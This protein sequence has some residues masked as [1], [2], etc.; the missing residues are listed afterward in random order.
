MLR[1]GHAPQ[2]GQV[3]S[4]E[5]RQPAP[6]QP[7][8]GSRHGCLWIILFLCVVGVAAYIFR[9]R[10][11]PVVTQVF[12]TS[13]APTATLPPRQ[14]P[15]AV[16]TARRGDLP[17]YLDAPGTVSALETVAVKSRV[18]GQ[19]MKVFFTEGRMVKAGDL[20]FQIDPR[21]FE[22]Q[23]MQAQGQ[24][25]RDQ[26]LL[27][28]AQL[29][30]VRYQQAG[31]A[32][33][34]QQ[35]DTARAA[36]LQ[37]QGAVKVD[38]GVIENVNLQLSYCRITSP[39]DG[40]IGLELVDQGNIVHANDTTGLALISRL[41]PINVLFSLAQDYLPRIMQAMGTGGKLAV[42]VLS[43]DKS[44]AL[45][46]GTLEAV[47][48]QID[49]QTLT[50]RFK[51]VCANRNHNLFPNQA[52]NVRLLVE[53]RRGVVLIPTAAVQRGPQSAY[54]YVVKGGAAEMRPIESGPVEGDVSAIMRGLAPGE[55]VVTAGTD[56]LA[57]GMKVVVA[58][59]EAPRPAGGAAQ[60]TGP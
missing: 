15:V 48:S 36:V 1:I 44:M 3:M 27:Q 60:G 39:I 22:A 30:L 25:G 57:P 19:I 14:V 28:N 9:R 56:N 33:T 20:L 10:L 5:E 8:R 31:R 21:P 51:A 37:Y 54:A 35:L 45:T 38:Q 17:I 41:E 52:V 26:A 50:A 12:R 11:P 42:E 13:A 47:D 40:R 24:L 53:V 59:G 18:D 23:L 34:Q 55:V 7:P 58:P 49:P 16:A 29:D 32:A 2:G 4:D 46:S 43:R 6:E